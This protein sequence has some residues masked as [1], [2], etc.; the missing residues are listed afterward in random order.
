MR[1]NGMC[2]VVNKNKQE[3]DIDIT[4]GQWSNPFPLMIRKGRTREVIKDRYRSSLKRMID[5][6]ILKPEDLLELDGKRLGCRCLPKQPC[7]GDVLV[8]AVAWAKREMEARS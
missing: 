7:H 8:E 6:G 5:R 1:G 2:T 4:R 3:F